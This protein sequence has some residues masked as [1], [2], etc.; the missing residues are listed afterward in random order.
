[1]F[2]CVSLHA[3]WLV[4]ESEEWIAFCCFLLH[5]FTFPV[6]ATRSSIFE[7]TAEVE[8]EPAGGAMGKGQFEDSES[9]SELVLT[10]N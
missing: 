7:R 6:P 8:L 10:E 9:R 5:T 4:L 1:M 2:H 3:V